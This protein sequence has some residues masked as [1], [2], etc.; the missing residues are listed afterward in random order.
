MAGLSALYIRGEVHAFGAL[1]FGPRPA[2]LKN[3]PTAITTTLNFFPCKL[4]FITPS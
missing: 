2:A 1:D 3:A 4:A